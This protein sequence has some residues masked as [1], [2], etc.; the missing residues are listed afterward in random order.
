MS[1]GREFME[2]TKY[3][4]LSKSD[5]ERKLP[6]PPLEQPY[7]PDKP[8][9]ELPKVNPGEVTDMSL[10]RAI[11]ERQSRRSY[12]ED[13]L[14]AGELSFLLWSTQGIK[15]AAPKHTMRTVPSAGAR[16]PFETY[17]LIN[18]VRNEDGGK[19]PGGLYRYVASEHKLAEADISAGV[20]RR[21]TAACLNQK[22]VAASAITFVWAAMPYRAAWRYGERGYRYLHLDAGHVCQNLYLACEGIG[23]GCCAIAAFDDDAVNALIKMNGVDGFAIYLASVGRYKV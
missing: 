14:T 20:A 22:M 16:H 10:A 7:D 3:K 1:I 13:Y 5:Q 9:V 15:T 6:Q 11:A 21:L 17:L 2:Q 4:N 12:N 19:I 8:G 18:R 23:A